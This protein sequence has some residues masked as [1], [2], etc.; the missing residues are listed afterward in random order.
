MRRARPDRSAR[1]RGQLHQSRWSDVRNTIRPTEVLSVDQVEAIHEASLR[2][3]ATTGMRV[4]EPD[5]RQR[6]ERA[7]AVVDDVTR[8]RTHPLVPAGIPVYGYVYD[9]RTGKLIEIPEATEAGK[10]A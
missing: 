10:A 8:I 7:G 4:L 1:S 9:V 5:A 3:L 6:F 2:L